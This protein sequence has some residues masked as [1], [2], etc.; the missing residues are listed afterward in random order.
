MLFVVLTDKGIQ[1]V[2]LEATSQ[3]DAVAQIKQLYGQGNGQ[4]RVGLVLP[5][6]TGRLS[7]DP[8]DPAASTL[9]M[10][11]DSQTQQT[12]RQNLQTFLGV[13]SPSNAQV[14]AAVRALARLAVGDFTG[15]S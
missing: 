4:I 3:A 1:T 6:V 12:I 8:N 7:Q 15:S 11:G 10:T 2:P 14:V 13:Q 5:D 9:N